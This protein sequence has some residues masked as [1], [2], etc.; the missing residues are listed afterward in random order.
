M[1]NPDFLKKAEQIF[2]QLG[3]ALDLQRVQSETA[4]ESPTS[5]N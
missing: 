5:S 3:A 4:P 2:E 1:K